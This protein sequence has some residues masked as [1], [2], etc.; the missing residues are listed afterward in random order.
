MDTETEIEIETRIQEEI[1]RLLKQA[2][3]ARVGSCLPGRA[4]YGCVE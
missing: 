4:G 3:T 2:G 1:A